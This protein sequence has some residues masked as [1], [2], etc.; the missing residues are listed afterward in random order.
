[1]RIYKSYGEL[2]LTLR[3]E[4]VAQILSI[5]RAVANDYLMKSLVNSLKKMRKG[6]PKRKV[7]FTADEIRSFRRIKTAGAS[8]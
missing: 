3:V 8:V 7:A 5:S 4:E 6:P 1:M 2:P